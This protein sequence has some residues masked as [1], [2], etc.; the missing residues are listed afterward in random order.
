[1]KCIIE[2]KQSQKERRERYQKDWNE[3]KAILAPLLGRLSLC[4]EW[5]PLSCYLNYLQR[6]KTQKYTPQAITEIYV[7]CLLALELFTFFF[8]WLTGCTNLLW[9]IPATIFLTMR[10]LDILQ[11]WAKV[12]LVASSS[13]V[14][15]TRPRR[16]LILTLVNYFEL[17]LNFVVL[18]SV[19]QPEFEPV[20]NN[21]SDGVLMVIG[22]MTTIGT[23]FSPD[24]AL[25]WLFYLSEIAFGLFFILIVIVRVLTS[26]ESSNKS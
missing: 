8:T 24:S 9:A 13:N 3:G 11:A 26:F 5:L 16:L 19:W 14:L 4:L 21:F 23:E 15:T 25:A 17:I 1:M 7:L 2:L 20:L 10:L 18:V 6:T 22:T 12:L